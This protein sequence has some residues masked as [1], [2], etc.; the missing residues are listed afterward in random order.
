M[1]QAAPNSLKP[2]QASKGE[3]A[4]VCLMYSRKIGK[5]RHRAKALKAQINSAPALSAVS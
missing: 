2:K 3:E 5:V 4:V 1:W